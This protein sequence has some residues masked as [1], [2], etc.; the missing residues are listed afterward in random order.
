MGGG[1]VAEHEIRAD[2]DGERFGFV[3]RGGREVI[4]AGE[5]GVGIA[6]IEIIQGCGEADNERESASKR[7]GGGER[8][9]C[10]LSMFGTSGEFAK[11]KVNKRTRNK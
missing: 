10:H 7:G 2:L 11:R 6:I 5:G 1:D 3:A 8:W 4:D 9:E